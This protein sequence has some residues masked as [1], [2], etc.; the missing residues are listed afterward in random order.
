MIDWPER[1][2]CIIL[3]VAILSN[4]LLV[5]RMVNAWAFPAVIFSLAWFLYTIIPL[6]CFPN[7]HVYPLAMLYIFGASLAVSIG[8]IS[9]WQ[10]AFNQ[11]QGL[12]E[13]DGSYSS[14]KLYLYFY[15]AYAVTVACLLL[16]SI[17]QGISIDQLVNNI[18]DSAA[19]YAGRRYSYDI[20]PNVYQQLGNVLAYSCAGLGGVLL[21]S[22]N[23]RYM[24]FVIVFVSL[25][26]A[27]F[28]MLSQSA[29]G[30]LFLCAAIFYAGVLVAGLL[31]GNTYLLSKKAIPTLVVLAILVIPLVTISFV[32]RGVSSGAGQ[33]FIDAVAPLW[34]SYT[35][36]HLFAFSDWFGNYIGSASIQP[37]DDP[38]MTNGFYT[39]MSVFKLFGDDRPVP[40]GVYGEYL[41]IPPYIGT[42]IYTAFRGMIHDFGIAGSLVMLSIL[43]YL[44]HIAFRTMLRSASPALS[45]SAFLF[46]VSFIYQS[47]IISAIMWN[48]LMIGLAF[49][50]VVLALSRSNPAPDY[51]GNMVGTTSSN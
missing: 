19:E 41:T 9:N 33:S 4:A 10:S 2:V 51:A 48:T 28:V 11:R 39:F 44:S 17:S 35:S 14:G 16:N 18:N 46:T 27:V 38:G 30:M 23:K 43:S 40:I 26:P 7:A 15:L 22:Q 24:K 20:A 31:R 34:A 50:G 12:R 13:I 21:P 6:V 5:R 8:S 49:V 25:S 3:S 32:A 42:N 37:Y 1:I 45:V 36:G 29:R 47:F